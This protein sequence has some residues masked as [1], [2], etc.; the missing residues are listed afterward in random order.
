MYGGDHGN[1]RSRFF[2]YVR[3]TVRKNGTLTGDGTPR[4]GSPDVRLV[5][6]VLDYKRAN[7][8][9][10]GSHHRAYAA[11]TRVQVYYYCY[12]GRHPKTVLGG[13]RRA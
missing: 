2:E 5:F 10:H 9:R 6:G 13:G 3:Q 8:S 4:N 1:R 12:V 7:V 11:H